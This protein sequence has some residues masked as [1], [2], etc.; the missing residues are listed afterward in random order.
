MKKFEVS[1]YGVEEMNA[2]QAQEVNGGII[3]AWWASKV[4]WTIGTGLI[5][6]LG[7]NWPDTAE[8]FK[9]GYNDARN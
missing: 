2:R 3:W 5:Y 4:A 1:A 8:S 9:E 7:S 6:D